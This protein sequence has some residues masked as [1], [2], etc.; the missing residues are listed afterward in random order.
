M[1]SNNPGTNYYPHYL[2]LGFTNF[3]Q[4]FPTFTPAPWDCDDC[5]QGH[6]SP[7]MQKV[8]DYHMR[9]AK[10]DYYE[11]RDDLFTHFIKK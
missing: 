1:N 4:P 9:A 8:A 5:D 7:P 2:A 6:S 3:S 10:K 11:K